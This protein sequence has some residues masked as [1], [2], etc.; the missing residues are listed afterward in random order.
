MGKLVFKRPEKGTVHDVNT[1]PVILG[2]FFLIAALKYVNE[3]VVMLEDKAE[4]GEKWYLQTNVVE[5]FLPFL[6]VGTNNTSLLGQTSC[7]HT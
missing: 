3:L 4:K 5:L 7:R 6:T 1:A 2:D